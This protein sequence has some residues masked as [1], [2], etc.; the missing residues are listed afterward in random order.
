M[1]ESSQ[2]SK[3]N[4]TDLNKVLMHMIDTNKVLQTKN[5]VPIALNVVG[6][7]GLGKTSAIKQAGASLGY[8]EENIV[9][10]NLS[11]FE[12][13]GDL[14]GIPVT[15]YKMAQQVET[16]E[17]QPAQY[18]VAWVKEG[19]MDAYANAGYKTTNQSRMA[20]STPEWISGK[21]G[22]GILILDDYTRA[23]QRFTQAVMELIECQEYASWSLPEG[24]TIVLSSN[25]DD[26]MYNVTDQDPAQKSRY[27]NVELGFDSEI[28]AQWA[29]KHSIDSR[30]INFILMNKELISKSGDEINARSIT[31]FFNAISTIKNFNTPENLELIQILGE[32]SL[33]VDATTMFTAF[34]HNK[35]DKLMSSE[36]ILDTTTPF[37]SIEKALTKVIKGN[38]KGDEQYRGDIAYVVTTRLLNHIQ[39]SMDEVD[40]DDD[41]KERMEDLLNTDV[42]GSDLKFIL[43]RKLINTEGGKFTFLCFNKSVVENILE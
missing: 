4:I 15:E 18:K 37:E 23:S 29:E 31:K 34:I 43:G 7:A 9:K 2:M 11:T 35:M 16:P 40:F 30:C 12:E 8:K 21:T 1:N 41:L 25:P 42:F 26:G 19:A 28:W 5:H 14:I 38:K 3:V 20:Y 36:E 33:G 6:K 17:G 32:G 13:I 24:W 27:M 22:P 10:L 39:Y